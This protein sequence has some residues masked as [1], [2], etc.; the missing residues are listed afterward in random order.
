M[1]RRRS[2]EATSQPAGTADLSLQDK[3]RRF[4]AITRHAAASAAAAAAASLT[5]SE[6]VAGRRHSA[7]ARRRR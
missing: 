6:W 4:K 3:L 1:R 7:A 2:E 5:S